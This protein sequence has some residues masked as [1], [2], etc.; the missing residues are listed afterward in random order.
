[1]SSPLLSPGVP[2]LRCG[3]RCGPV[4]VVFSLLLAEHRGAL[5]CSLTPAG[6]ADGWGMAWSDVLVHDCGPMGNDCHLAQGALAEGPLTSAA[7]KVEG[8]FYAR[9]PRHF[10]IMRR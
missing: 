7:P 5:A 3:L 9:Q 2:A 4:R 8:D 1:M 10:N 6:F